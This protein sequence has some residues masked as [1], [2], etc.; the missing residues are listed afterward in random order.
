MRGC[1][2]IAI[3]FIRLSGLPSSGHRGSLGWQ[4]LEH[5]RSTESFMLAGTHV[6]KAVTSM[7]LRL[8]EE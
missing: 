6:T 4:L 5:R 2:R 3:L 7:M 8:F 1:G